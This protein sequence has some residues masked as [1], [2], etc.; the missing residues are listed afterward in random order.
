[1][2]KTEEER[3]KAE[4]VK[5]TYQSTEEITEKIMM[6]GL[7]Q[8][9]SRSEIKEEIARALREHMKAKNSEVPSR[10]QEEKKQAAEENAAKESAEE[11]KEE[12]TSDAYNAQ[13]DF[14]YIVRQGSRFGFHFMLCMNQLADLK[15]TRLQGELFRHKLVFQLSTEDSRSFL[16]S[17]AAAGLP[18]RICLYSNALEQYSLRPFIHE[19]VNWD[20]WDL[21]ENQEAVN[22]L[23]L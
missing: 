9:K 3:K 13:E 1:M 18:E 21:D 6:D 22:G 11:E 17:R 10:K 12:K 23:H 2:A 14:R 19:G 15:N 5:E 8:G 16:N 20:G 4:E 7:A